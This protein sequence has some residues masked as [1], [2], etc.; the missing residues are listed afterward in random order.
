MVKKSIRT[1]F[2]KT[3]SGKLLRRKMGI[4]HFKAKKTGAQKRNKKK[5]IRVKNVDV[6][7]MRRY[8]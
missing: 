2:K 8:I 1:R 3:K 6:K 7:T 4:S 5:N